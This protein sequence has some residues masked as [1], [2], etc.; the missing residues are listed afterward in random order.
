MELDSQWSLLMGRSSDSAGR[1]EFSVFLYAKL[2]PVTGFLQK[3][4]GNAYWGGIW[5]SFGVLEWGCLYL[6]L[7]SQIPW[8]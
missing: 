2:H 8:I 5:P 3:Q 4:N 7:V 6:Y 1:H